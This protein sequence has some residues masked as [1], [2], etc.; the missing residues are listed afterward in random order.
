M[1]DP[2]V[3]LPVSRP[4][5][6]R[7]PA[8]SGELAIADTRRWPSVAQ[9]VQ[10]LAYNPDALATA[11]GGLQIY[12]KM[13]EDDQVK[14]CLWLTKCAIVGPG[15]KL[16]PG[17]DS[18]RAKSLAEQLTENLEHLDGL[19]TFDD[20][21]AEVLAALSYGYSVAEKIYASDGTVVRLSALKGRAPHAITFQ[22]DAF[23]NLEFIIQQQ[24]G[25]RKEMDP[26]RF[27][28]F[29]IEPEFGNPYG[30][31]LLREA[32]RPY[33]YKNNV[34]QWW[35][36]FLE[37]LAIPPIYGKHPPAEAGNAA[38]VLDVLKR[39]QAG[40]AL[41]VGDGWELG[42]LETTRDPRAV[43]ES[44]VDHHNLGI[45]RACLLFDKS[46]VAGKNVDA[47]SRALAQTQF[48]TWLLVLGSIQRRLLM[49]IQRQ[50][51]DE[52][53]ELAAPGVPAPTLQFLPITDRNKE[54]LADLWIKAVTSGAALATIEDEN[55]LRSEL[56]F[57][58]RVEDARDAARVAPPQV[59][60]PG[61]PAPS[62]APT[63]AKAQ[64]AEYAATGDFWRPLTAT[65]T[66]ANLAETRQQ[67]TTLETSHGAVVAAAIADVLMAVRKTAEK[68][69]T[70]QSV[71]DLAVPK[72]VETILR[73][74]VQD[75]LHAG[76]ASGQAKAAQ[77]VRAAGM[78]ARFSETQEAILIRF[79]DRGGLVGARALSFF[80]S[81]SVFVTGITLDD[82][83]KRTQ[84]V[85]FSA[86]KQDKTPGQVMFEVDRAMADYLPA[87]DAAGRVTNVP[88]RVENIVRTNLAEAVNEGRWAAFNDPDLEGFISMVRYSAVMDDRTRETHAAWD[89]VTRPMDDQVWF[90]PPD[91]RPPNG[92]QCRCILIPISIADGTEQ[93]PDDEVPSEPAADPGFK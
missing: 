66:R 24:G 47:G 50:L 20:S 12:D 39:L 43:F 15:W 45:A 11:K 8:V 72:T 63:P 33:W 14:A 30:R 31:S 32:Y 26:A 46:G 60:V 51:V 54:A 73:K 4:R 7:T 5:K 88:A 1:A 13:R 16:M 75:M 38:H 19:R 58:E 71:R 37:K 80:N 56:E 84:T 3:K 44:A 29:T 70:A 18:A 2:A 6:P 89:G 83:L 93:T 52:L 59:Q 40:T 68:A 41:T 17:D 87:T 48:D 23:D 9:S 36:M 91:N 79:A 78:Q 82:I 62:P 35:A 77:E 25:Q 81:K 42:M 55:H 21:L 67:F 57:P 90:G 65:E 27:V 74:A 53:A 76:Y 61:E 86:L 28:H 34:I 85:L 64:M 92:F 69:T 10:Y 22:Q 49:T